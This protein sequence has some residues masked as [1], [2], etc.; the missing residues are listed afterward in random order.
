[1][2]EEGS[3]MGGGGITNLEKRLNLEVEESKIGGEI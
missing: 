1:M 2:E 3:K